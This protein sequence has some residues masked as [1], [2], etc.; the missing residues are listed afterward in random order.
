MDLAVRIKDLLGKD[1]VVILF[2]NSSR[3]KNIRQC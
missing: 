2:K 3:G 1:S